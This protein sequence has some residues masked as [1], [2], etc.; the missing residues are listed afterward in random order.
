M[1]KYHH[2]QHEEVEEGE[3]NWLISYA[4]LMTLLWGF[5][6]I[7]AA[8]STPDPTKFEKLK[9]KT[10]ESMGGS[11][12]NPFN[13]LTDQLKDIF[14]EENIEHMKVEVLSDGL[15]ITSSSAYFFDIGKAKLHPNASE[16]LKKLAKVIKSSSQSVIVHIEGHTDDVPINNKEFPSNWDL[17]LSRASEVVK[18]FETQG[19]EH[20]ALRPVG[21]ADVEPELRTEN[22]S[23]AELEAARSKNRRIVIR[24]TKVLI[25]HSK[26][27]SDSP[28]PSK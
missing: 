17:S 21:L 28:A 8:F 2:K 25:S 27:K 3:G 22:L 1:K 26:T 19:I 24:L 12:L 14:K 6:V 5:F 23:G 9:K 4:D 18:L 13:K 7:I 10:A 15:K 20:T 11:Y 16:V